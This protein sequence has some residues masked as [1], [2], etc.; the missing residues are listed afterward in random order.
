M[1]VLHRCCAGLDVHKRTVVAC[2]RRVDPD[3]KVHRKVHRKVRTFATMTAELMGLA[4]WLAACGGLAVAMESTGSNWKPVFNI[5]ELLF[6]RAI[7]ELATDGFGADRSAGKGQFHV[8]GEPEPADFLDRVEVPNG[9]LVLS[10]FQPDAGDPT[11]GAWDAFTKYGK[12]GPEFGLE[13]VFKRPLVLRKPG[14]CFLLPKARPWLGRAVAVPSGPCRPESR[15]PPAEPGQLAEQGPG[16][17][18]LSAHRSNQTTNVKAASQVQ[19]QGGDQ[20]RGL[21]C[22]SF[23]ASPPWPVVR[24]TVAHQ[25]GSARVRPQ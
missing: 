8:E 1:D 11:D 20:S 21:S 3:G 18:H 17:D 19:N 14:A 4:D 16:V 23:M 13:N 15:S 25:R 10:T 22:S 2:V 6:W 12:L 7:H 5:L 9:L 24:L